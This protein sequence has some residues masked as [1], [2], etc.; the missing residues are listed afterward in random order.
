M[1]FVGTIT[2]LQDAVASLHDL[3]HSV[4]NRILRRAL[5]AGAKP[6]IKAARQI[7]PVRTRQMKKALGSTIRA[8]VSGIVVAII[9]VRK[10]F[11]VVIDGKPVDP[12][13]YL[14][15]VLY[16]RAA[17][18]IR[19]TD[20]KLLVAADNPNFATAGGIEGSIGSHAMVPA[21]KGNDFLSAALAAGKAECVANVTRVIQEELA[22]LRAKAV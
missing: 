1:K 11:R 15:L 18:D 2:G 16:G 12:S 21:A 13:K 20:K 9:G 17:E 19:A 3:R 5:T 14:H 22:K 10:G 8:Y 7:V 4:R 6:I